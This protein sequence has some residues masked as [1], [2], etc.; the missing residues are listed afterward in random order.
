MMVKIPQA[1][2][3][4]IYLFIA[5]FLLCFLFFAVR[6]YIRITA[7]VQETKRKREAME[8]FAK[9]KMFAQKRHEKA[10]QWFASWSRAH[11]GENPTDSPEVQKI[12]QEC[13]SA[14]RA[15]TGDEGLKRR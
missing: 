5:W 14:Y 6:A 15:M 3:G 7:H 9:E 11:P 1:L 13:A 4:E 12:M 10:A 2:A 8:R